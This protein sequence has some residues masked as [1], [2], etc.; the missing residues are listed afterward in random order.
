MKLWTVQPPEV[1]TIVENSGKFACDTA[2]SENYDDFHDAYLWLV[3]EMDKR[4]IYHPP[5]I[6]LPL[7]AWHTMDWKHKKPDFRC[8]GLGAPKKQY[9]C[10]EFEIPDDQVLLSDHNHWHFVLNDSWFD[11]STCEKEFDEIHEWYDSLDAKTKEE[12]KK[13]SWQKIFDVKPVYTDW[14]Q[15]GRYIQATF[16]ELRKEMITDVKYFVAK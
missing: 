11:N 15:T 14:L 4:D 3:Q 12:L 9:V 13:K 10:I 16:W 6:Q 5:N 1:I 7:W 2:L 8:A